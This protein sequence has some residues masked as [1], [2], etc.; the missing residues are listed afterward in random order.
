MSSSH[1]K[2]G[3]VFGA[4]GVVERSGTEAGRSVAE[5]KHEK[6]QLK[7]FPIKKRVNTELFINR[8]V[9]LY[10]HKMRRRSDQGDRIEKYWTS[11]KRVDFGRK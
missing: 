11:W 5:E 3:S 2:T 10:I 7:P 4:A 1:F 8:Q 6:S 9:M